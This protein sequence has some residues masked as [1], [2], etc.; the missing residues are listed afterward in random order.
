MAEKFPIS[1]WNYNNLDDFTS[2]EV[3]VWADCGLT[4]TM[5][6]K[7]VYGKDDP[8]KIIPFLDVAEKR[9]IK[10]IAYVIGLESEFIRELGLDGYKARFSE[11][12]SIIKHPAL[13]GFFIGDEPST[14]EAFEDSVNCVKFQ[15]ETAPELTPYLNL[16]TDMDATEPE[17]L[18]GKTFRQWLKDFA[19][20]TGFSLFSYG[21][22]DQV[23]DE[24]GVDSYFRNLKAL[25]SA[26]NDAGVDCWNTQLSSAHYMF[27]IPN[28]YE[29][30]WQ[31]TTAAACGS[32]GINWFRFYDRSIGPNYH[33]SPIDEYGNKTPLY[34]DMLRANRRFND[35]YG[36][37]IMRSKLKATYFT[38][39]TY[40][41]Y[42]LFT[43]LVH[44]IIKEVISTEQAIVSFFEDKTDGS[45][46]L[47]IVNAS[48][49]K[50]GVFRPGFDR[51][52]YSLTEIMLNGKEEAPYTLGESLAH[53]DGQWLYPGQ[54]NMF[55]I[56]HK[57][58]TAEK[59]PRAI[60]SN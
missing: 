56:E 10:L 16:H 9:G 4:V 49:D 46:Y 28:G 22:Y 33:G 6:P 17:L 3:N 14:K 21:H 47:C 34:Y 13:Y 42:D 41:G 1:I 45:E 59:A 53:W 11:V 54:M 31:I 27:R 18:G 30:L 24:N 60:W 48:M 43:S 12:Y 19:K 29:T 20:D 26:A 44:P 25:V 40:G 35:Q 57:A 7:I 52:K 50:P 39:K 58:S 37:I 38:R 15:K 36:E 8:K 32:R 5:T 55:R 51:E 23:W 2:D